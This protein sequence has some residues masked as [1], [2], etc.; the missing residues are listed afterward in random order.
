MLFGENEQIMQ[1]RYDIYSF[2][3]SLFEAYKR[4]EKN[5]VLVPIFKQYQ[6]EL[7]K[8]LV[9]YI[10]SDFLDHL[11]KNNVC[12]L[13]IIFS[14]VRVNRLVNIFFNYYFPDYV[15]HPRLEEH[16]E[17][18]LSRLIEYD[19]FIMSKQIYTCYRESIK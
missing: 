1:E 8:I 10:K 9:P 3:T 19:K 15:I 6:R 18:I 16:E 4:K 12:S 17:D 7:L 13:Y 11:I 5:K 2:K 14:G